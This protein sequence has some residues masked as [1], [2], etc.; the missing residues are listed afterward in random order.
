M[1]TMTAVSVLTH[2]F[3]QALLS[4]DE[5]ALADTSAIDLSWSIPGT[6]RISGLHVGVPAVI[7]VAATVR[8]HGIAIEVEQIL[9]G[10]DGV[11]AI[12][13]ETGTS[14][15]RSLDVRVAL[16]LL[17]RDDH[18]A[19]MTGFISDVAAYDNFLA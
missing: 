6:G 15:T 14:G 4:L 8:Q 1:S 12:L 17:I 11:T 16:A 3:A 2:R 19:T 5:A 7:A 13:H 18:V 10:V 9:I